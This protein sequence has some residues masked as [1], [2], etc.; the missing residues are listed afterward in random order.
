MHHAN[1]DRGVHRELACSLY[2]RYMLVETPPAS[3]TG[4]SAICPALHVGGSK[5][6]LKSLACLEALCQPRS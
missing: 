4:L 6:S 3:C 1:Y 5:W 2:L